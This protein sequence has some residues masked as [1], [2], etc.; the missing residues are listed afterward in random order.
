MTVILVMDN[1]CGLSFSRCS[2]ENQRT[3]WMSDAAEY[4]S[5]RHSLQRQIEESKV[6]LQL[7]M[8][9]VRC[10]QTSKFWNPHQDM[11]ANGYNHK[12]ITSLV[13]VTEVYVK[14]S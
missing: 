5:R 6:T 3:V 4:Q 13:H 12:Q 11:A 7:K 14:A 9:Q 1:E 2:N 8:D 10:S